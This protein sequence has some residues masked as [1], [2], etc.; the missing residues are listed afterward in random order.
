MVCGTFP[1][2]SSVGG[3]R[4]AMFSKYL[5]LFGWQPIIFTRV[6]PHSDPMYDPKMEIDGVPTMEKRINVSY[7]TNE[8]KKFLENRTIFQ[9]TKHFFCPDYAHPPGLLDRMNKI[10]VEKIF[11]KKIDAVWGTCGPLGCLTIARNISKEM[12]IPWIADFRDIHEQDFADTFRLKLLF[13]RNDYRR[14]RIVH[15]AASVITVSDHHAKLLSKNLKAP[16]SIIQNGYDPEMFS[17]APSETTNKFTI[18]YMGRILYE[19][20]RNPKPFLGA[21]DF[22]IDSNKI[23]KEDLDISFYG[24]EPEILSEI[25]KKYKCQNIIHAKPRIHFKEVPSILKKSNVL[26]TL[27]ERN[28]KGILTTKI[29]EYL[30]VKRPILCVPKDGSDLEDLIKQTNSGVSCSSKEDISKVLKSWYDEWKSTGTVQC[31]SHYNEILRFSRKE[32]A[33]QLAEHLDNIT[34]KN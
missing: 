2:E 9:K 19:W 16:V 10:W 5:P 26:L 13:K 28:R 29:F 33:K 17:E 24:T 7:S 34:H 3:L 1:P 23:N 31:N 15:S 32:Q 6:L 8:E 18:T 14:K 25:K 4:P 21:I 20:L 12:K 30:G 27:T 22:L 11:K